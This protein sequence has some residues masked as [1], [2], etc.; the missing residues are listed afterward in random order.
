M[1]NNYG[2]VSYIQ[3]WQYFRLL[4]VSI[5]HLLPSLTD[6]RTMNTVVQIGKRLEAAGLKNDAETRRAYREVLFSHPTIG[7]WLAGAI[8][9][10]ETLLQNT[11]DGIPFPEF[12]RLKGVLP[13]VK[14]DKGLEPIPSS[15]RETTTRGMDTLLERS[16]SYYEQGARFAKW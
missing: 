15:P 6:Q 13:G 4:T 9:F 7:D 10:E 3:P 5:P 11:V 12:L 2:C 1:Q 14:T 8:L 16:K